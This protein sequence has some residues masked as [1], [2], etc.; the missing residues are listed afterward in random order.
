M[1]IGDRVRL[2]RGTEEGIIVNI[3]KDKLVEVEIEDGFIIPVLKNE[4]VLVHPKEADTFGRQVPVEESSGPVHTEKSISEGFYFAVSDHMLESEKLY[5]INHT[6]NTILYTISELLKKGFSG[7][8]YGALDPYSATKITSR[9]EI[10]HLGNK[11]LVI[12]AIFHEKEGKLKK[13]PLTVTISPAKMMTDDKVNV[14]YCDEAV[15]ILPIE[16]G[17]APSIDVEQLKQGMMEQIPL[18]PPPG[19]G[20]GVKERTIDLHIDPAESGLD[21]KEVLSHQLQQFE[22][23]YDEALLWNLE[24]LKIIHGVGAGILRNEIHRRLSQK[25]EVKYFEDA[26]KERFGFGSTVIYF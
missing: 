7:L 6:E 16:H 18:L 17:S 25:K 23:D 3:K 19:A 24:K 4:V 21:P 13:S 22:K 15:N 11:K 1:K 14:R 5:L 12:D 2:L 20:Y 8:A 26:D 9:R 10:A